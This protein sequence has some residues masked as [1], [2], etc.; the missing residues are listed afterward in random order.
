MKETTKEEKKIIQDKLK[1]LKL[2]LDNV[3]NIFE[4]INKINLEENISLNEWI[5]KKV[6]V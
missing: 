5:N 2:D 1:F 6:G 3:S 4:T